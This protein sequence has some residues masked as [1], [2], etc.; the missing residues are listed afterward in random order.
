MNSRSG[1]TLIEL[2]VVVGIVVIILIAATSLFYTTL[3]G[4]GKTASSE[5]VKQAGQYALNQMGYFLYNARKL[6]PNN[7]TLTCAQG[8]VSLA[9]QN[10]DLGITTFSATNVGGFVR[11]A[12]NSGTYLTPGN[13]T[14]SV[15]P[16]FNCTQPISGA[17][18]V[19]ISFTLQKGVVGIDKP[20]DI[21]SIPFTTQATLRN[22]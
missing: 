17:P 13:I 2:I 6:V 18:I 19:Q 3:I 12:S 1:Y 11:I 16:T 7:E 9:M 20:R 8:M 14:V 22:Y 15:G 21:I 5:A 10:Q 4:G